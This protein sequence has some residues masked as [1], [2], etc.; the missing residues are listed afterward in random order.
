[1][2]RRILSPV[3][4]A[5]MLKRLVP[6]AIFL[7]VAPTALAQSEPPA[8]A[9]K[10]ASRSTAEKNAE[11][12]QQLPFDDRADYE[13]VGRGL[14]ASYRDP[15]KDA[16][17][18][19]VWNMQTYDFQLTDKSPATVNPSL[20]RQAQLN[21]HA[22]LFK[23][24]D[25]V[26]Q[27]RG[28]DLANMSIVEGD[29]G[30]IIVDPLTT[31]ETARAALD[32]YYRHRPRKPVVAV[33][34]SHSHADHFGGVRGVVDEADVAAGKVAIYAPEGFMREAVS[35]NVLAGTAM[36][37]RTQYQLGT[38]VQSGPQGQVDTGIGKS[39]TSGGTISLIAP[40]VQITKPHETVRID[41]L[42]V[43][44]QLTP[45]SEAPAEMNLYLPQ[46]RALCIAETAARSM[47]NLL[48]PRGALVRDAKAW[49]QYLDDSL[50]R[51]GDRAD[52]MFLSHNWPTWGGDAI[53]TVLA[54]ERDMY[55]FLNDRT[56]HLL[57]QGLTPMEISEAMRKLPG[58]LGRK[59]YNRG[60]YGSLSFNSRAV[61]Q[62]YLGF[63]DGN[64]ANLNPLPP[65]EAG[66]Q[67]VEA[68]GGAEKVLAAIGAASARG[69][70][71]W[72]VE[73]G[74]HLVFA[75][76]EDRRAREAQADALEQLGYQSESAIWRNM[77]LSGAAEL[78]TGQ[79]SSVR[80]DISDL[81]RALE[82]DMFFDYLAI[83]LD[84]E[85]AV[86]HDMTLNWTITDRRQDF[87]L[88]VRNGVLSYR[89]DRLHPAPDTSVAMS[90]AVLDRIGVRQLDL[91]TAI[92]Q[93]DIRI[94]GDRA[95]LAELMGL[96]ATFD[97]SFN[98]V[99]P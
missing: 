86:G 5:R 78:R 88:T 38:P 95:K 75:Y 30:L 47:H 90:K 66:K 2:A 32:L 67:Y 3:H 13:A 35:E 74:N 85:R 7:V 69:D 22:G 14:I 54:D 25:R 99:T 31:I 8:A 83:R 55:K 43:E 96:L 92:G 45:N 12:L 15:I 50:V 16:D 18:R 80:Q 49:S 46:L 62:R 40:T 20:W 64:P 63:Y 58:D 44:F 29:T 76:P 36:F 26:Y 24:T 81:G 6:A 77:Y 84:A 27:V 19:I 72:A 9:A 39:G 87:A 82:P 61:Y 98:I 42:D 94:D 73:L 17:G 33:I 79:R 68:M 53:R 28:L 71:R 48:T 11:V 93:G 70:Y 21:N 34:Y 41:G 97:P 89:K 65:E 51:Y 1:M 10:P 52:V 23:V 91:A 57:N 60:Y 59:W 56:L 37:R 4:S